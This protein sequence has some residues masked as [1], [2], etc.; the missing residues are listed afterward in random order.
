MNAVNFLRRAVSRL[1]L[2]TVYSGI[3]KV[4]NRVNI[5]R[6]VTISSRKNLV[7]GDDVTIADYCRISGGKNPGSVSI[8][9]RS[10][11]H[12]FCML[13]PFGG[14]IHIGSDT[15]LNPYSMIY[16]GDAGVEIGSNVMIAPHTLIFASNHNFSRRDVPM[17]NQGTTS[18]GVVIED[19]VWIG[20][21]CRILDGVRI[22]SGSIIAAGAVVTRSI[23]DCS[24]VGGVP[25]RPLRQR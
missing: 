18:K 6:A 19:D 14:S 12:Q 21:G 20:A 9:E 23:D 25:A 15:T 5:G 8:G 2:Y 24:V 7:L 11:I 17:R 3:G 16:G 1:R 22:C 10:F 13:R 4:G